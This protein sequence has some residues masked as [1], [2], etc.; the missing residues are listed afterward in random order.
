MCR[1]RTELGR[2]SGALVPAI[3]AQRPAARLRLRQT[4]KARAD[5]FRRRR[6]SRSQ[7]NPRDPAGGHLLRRLSRAN[8]NPA[9]AATGET[10]ATCRHL[11]QVR[12]IAPLGLSRGPSLHQAARS[13]RIRAA[14]ILEDSLDRIIL[15]RA[16]HR[17]SIKTTLAGIPA[18][19][20]IAG[21]LSTCSS[22]S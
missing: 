16:N 4:R 13:N 19:L 22:R 21:R 1:S 17:G 11:S 9:A 6:S 5:L 20:A 8:R 10:R 2:D 15:S 12:Q 14:G 7:I 18:D 3:P